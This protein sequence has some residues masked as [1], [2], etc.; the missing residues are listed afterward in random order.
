[1][2][3]LNQG[4]ALASFQI[5][6]RGRDQWQLDFTHQRHRV[7][8]EPCRR[9]A[10]PFEDAHDFRKCA[11]WKTPKIPSKVR[12]L[13][14]GAHA[15]VSIFARFPS[16]LRVTRLATQRRSIGSHSVNPF[17]GAAPM[18]RPGAC[19]RTSSRF[20]HPESESGSPRRAYNC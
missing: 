11:S 14:Q 6:H 2:K 5:G 20:G 19:L 16:L 9:C 15:K 18:A 7:Q 1:M 13:F 12:T 4:K 10:P 3:A 17:L 8:G